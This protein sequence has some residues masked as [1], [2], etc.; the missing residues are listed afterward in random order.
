MSQIADWLCEADQV[1]AFT[2]A[3]IST[4]SGIPDFRSPN[5]VWATNRQIDFQEFLSSADGRYEYWRQKSL[6]HR[7][8][9]DAQ[10][11]IGHR[12]LVRWE[13]QGK[14]RGVIT[15]N[16][17][18]LHQ[19]AGNSVVHELHGTA[20]DIACLSCSY[21]TPADPLVEQFLKTDLVP[22]CPECGRLLK[23]ATVSFGQSLPE[24]AF[25]ASVDL[26]RTSDL[27]FVLGSSL[28]VYPAAGIPQVAKQSG[29]R[30]VIIN[31]DETP[32]D[33]IADAVIRSSI[34]ET[35]AAIDRAMSA[36]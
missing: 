19:L 20:R 23:H 33:G 32:L 6:A 9:H 31:R 26:A 8:F 10:P 28:V 29:A 5:G 4:E 25:E 2:G 30:L 22:D 12:V 15:Q 21:R 36:T 7:A 35:L 17:D 27:F 34:G 24:E 14:L 3:G 13:Q 11:N 16:I 1:V 18:G